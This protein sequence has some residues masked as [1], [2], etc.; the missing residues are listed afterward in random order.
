MIDLKSFS[1]LTKALLLYTSL[2]LLQWTQIRIFF[3]FSFSWNILQFNFASLLIFGLLGNVF[4]FQIFMNFTHI[5]LLL[6]CNLTHLWSETILYDFK[7]V[8]LVLWSILVNNSCIFI[9]NILC[10]LA[11]SSKKVNLLKY[12]GCSD[13][14][15]YWFSLH[16]PYS[17][18]EINI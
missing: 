6:I 1:Y 14:L 9:K 15:S 5:F 2:V 13:I 18:W 3:S 11:D 4:Y 10:C 8:A 7:L 16:L 17:Y 12:L